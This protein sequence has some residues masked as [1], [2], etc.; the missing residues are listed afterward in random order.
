MRSW[1]AKK[2]PCPLRWTATEPWSRMQVSTTPPRVFFMRMSMESAGS[3]SR[4]HP[5]YSGNS[6][7]SRVP[8]LTLIFLTVLLDVLGFGLLIPVAPKFIA[9]IQGLPELGAEHDTSIIFGWL[10]ATYAIMQFVFSP[11]L[12]SLSDRFGRRPV[13][14]ISLFGS[15]LD[16]FV[17]AASPNIA[18]LFITRAINGISG[19]SITTCG[20]YIADIT[21]P[22]KRAAGFGIIGAAFGLGF[23]IGPLLGGILGAYDVRLPYVGA[24]VLTLINWLYGYFVLPASLSKELRQPFSWQKA[25]P[26]TSLKWIGSH[27]VVAVLAMSLFITNVAQFGLHSTWNLSMSSRFQWDPLHVGVSLFVV[28]V[29]AAIIQGGLARRIIPAVGERLCL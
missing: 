8:S 24:G 25:N 20:A 15:A 26:F 23:M 22:E 29:C 11:I 28:G 14:L 27:R 10:M 16:Y 17:A 4:A 6:M 3:N 9:R 21:P 5:C 7:K 1:S 2:P 18:I 12:G 19:A 13:I